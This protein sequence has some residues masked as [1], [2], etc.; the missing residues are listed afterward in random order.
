[1]VVF[2]PAPGLE[3]L[4]DAGDLFAV[5]KGL[6]DPRV[7]RWRRHRLG[8]V[9]AVTFSAFATPGFASLAGV[10]QWARDRSRAELLALGGWADPFDGRVHP[11]SEATIRRILTGIDAA[12]PGEPLIMPTSRPRSPP[13]RQDQR[14]L[15]A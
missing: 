6:P 9:L 15:S 8:Y 3:E 14:A 10:A 5:L 1:V 7:S 4:Q 13:H 12:L 2:C 11:P